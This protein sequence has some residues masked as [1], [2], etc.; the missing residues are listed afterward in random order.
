MIWCLRVASFICILLNSSLVYASEGTV[1]ETEC[2]ITE[3]M[4]VSAYPTYFKHLCDHGVSHRK[5][6]HKLFFVIIFIQSNLSQMPSLFR[7]NR[8]LKI[9]ISYPKLI[10]FIMIVKFQKWLILMFFPFGISGTYIKITW[11]K[12]K[13]K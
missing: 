1:S 12:T 7:Q 5:I 2:L 11:L 10:I 3:H 4:S 13:G 6:W 8:S 9:S